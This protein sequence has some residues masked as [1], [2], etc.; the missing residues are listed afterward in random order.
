MIS[1]QPK[2]KITIIG[3]GF[4]GSTAAHFCAEK[5]LGDIVLLDVNEGA[6]RGKALDLSEALPVMGRDAKVTGTAQYEDTANSD[7]VIIT[8]G[9][10]RKPGMSR[11]ELL[12]INAGIVRGAAENIK[13]YSPNAVVVVVTNPLDAMVFTA[14]RATGFPPQ[15]VLGMA[16]VLDSARMRFFIAE[17]LGVSVKDVTAFVLGGHGNTMVPLMRLAT[18]GGVPVSELLPSEKISQIITRTQNGGAEIVDLLKTGS[19]YYAPAA[20]I[21]EMAEAILRDQKR[22]LP[23][24][25]YLNGEYGV[26]GLFIGVPAVLGRNG[27]ERVVEIS[28][29]KEEKT[30]FEKTMKHVQELIGGFGGKN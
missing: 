17:A 18:A 24:A 2:P 26:K 25:A 11:D 29:Q 9:L 28:L 4:V 20:S 30:A 22:V 12:Q 8:A 10:A 6:A 21:A 23:C 3:A 7:L 14:W 15:R 5:E 19:A 13:K 27:V 1:S 16:G